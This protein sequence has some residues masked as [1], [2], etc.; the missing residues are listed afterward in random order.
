MRVS[1]SVVGHGLGSSLCLHPNRNPEP[2]KAGLAPTPAASAPSRKAPW[3]RGLPWMLYILALT[4]CQSMKVKP[5]VPVISA[6][7]MKISERPPAFQ[8]RA[9]SDNQD[10][11]YRRGDWFEIGDGA[12]TRYFIPFRVPG[13]IPRQKLIDEVIAARSEKK[14]REMIHK[15]NKDAAKNGG[16]FLLS[17]PLGFG[18]A[19][20]GG[21]IYD[22]R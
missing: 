7:W 14:Q 6:H 15:G 2:M 3:S 9:C 13:P 17:L 5:P 19:L 12:G 8:P 16:L 11:G 22:R 18:A 10:T 1:E 20:G 21:N 4:S